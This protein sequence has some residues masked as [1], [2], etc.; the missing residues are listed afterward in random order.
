MAYTIIAA[1]CVNCGACEPACPNGAISA[2]KG[3]YV[4]DPDTCTECRKRDDGPQCASVCP[5]DCCVP[6]TT[7]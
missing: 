7:H 5:T 3:T 1:E 6:A 4:I 2:R